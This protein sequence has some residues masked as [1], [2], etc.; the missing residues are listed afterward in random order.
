M[1]K[2]ENCKFKKIM[3][4]DQD[5]D[6]TKIKILLYNLYTNFSFSTFPYLVYKEKSSYNSFKKFN[7]GNCIS[8]CYFIKNYIK[9][10]Y[11]IDSFII[12]ASVPD[13]FKVEGTP[14]ICHCAVL[15]PKSMYEFYI[16]DGALY[17]LEGM[18][19]DTRNNV[20][21]TIYNSN[22]HRHTKTEI[23][24]YLDKCNS[25][26]LDDKYN[27]QLHPNS[28]FVKAEFTELENQTWNYYLNEIENPDN[29]ISI[30]F[31]RNKPKP[32]IMYTV[33]EDEIVKLK[34]KIYYDDDNDISIKEYPEGNII[35]KGNT[36]DN[37][38]KYLNIKNSLNKYFLD[39]I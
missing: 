9:K 25:C 11:N 39:F 4:F 37:N 27:Q 2:E 31:L 19:C 23:K 28:L 29:N 34:Y 13:I 16:I 32:F 1:D 26:K 8:F 7:S 10:N 18:Y 20:P 30:S 38:E 3:L 12:G 24:Y 21:R 17:F 15:I 36:Y 35:Y 33:Y 22:A 5:I 14:H 6:E